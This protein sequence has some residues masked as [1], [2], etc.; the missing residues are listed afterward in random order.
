MWAGLGCPRKNFQGSSEVDQIKSE[1]GEHS[2][3]DGDQEKTGAHLRGLVAGE[4]LY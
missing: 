3:S 2:L 1:D 4:F